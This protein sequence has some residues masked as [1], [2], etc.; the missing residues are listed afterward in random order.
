MFCT[1]LQ[2]KNTCGPKESKIYYCV[3]Q[4]LQKK[5][6]MTGSELKYNFV[7]DNVKE[8]LP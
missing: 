5:F 6:G 2:T 7:D 1:E 8:G 4:E 3:N